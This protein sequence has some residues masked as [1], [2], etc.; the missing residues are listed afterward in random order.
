MT[1]QDEIPLIGGLL[2]LPLLDCEGRY[3]GIVDDVEFAD[4]RGAPRVTALLVGPGAY[5]GRLPGW[6]FAIVRRIAGAHVTRVPWSAVKTIGSAVELRL[7][8][9][10]LGLD[11]FEQRA[12]QLLPHAG[13]L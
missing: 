6:A 9:G 12:E 5:R 11:R 10:D 7:A 1:P 8:A 3:C 4:E 13:A 2:D